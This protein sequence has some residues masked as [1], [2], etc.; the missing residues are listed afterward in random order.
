MPPDYGEGPSMALNGSGLV[1]IF[2]VSSGAAEVV[3][4]RAVSEDADGIGGFTYLLASSRL[5]QFISGRSRRNQDKTVRERVTAI[6]TTTLT[7]S[8]QCGS[9]NRIAKKTGRC[10]R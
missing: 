4:A 1:C 2:I 7:T 6:A 9:K 10:Q 3:E 8:L 5:L